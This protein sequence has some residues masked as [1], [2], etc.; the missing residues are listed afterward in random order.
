MI[1]INNKDNNRFFKQ[2]YT[3]VTKSVNLGSTL[4]IPGVNINN[5]KAAKS[6][7]LDLKTYYYDIYQKINGKLIQFGYGIPK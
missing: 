7:G 1:K 4:L 5:K 2:D 6:L 3:E